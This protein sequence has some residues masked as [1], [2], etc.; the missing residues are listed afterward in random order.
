MART[1][2]E[3]VFRWVQPDEAGDRST[4]EVPTAPSAE[5]RR[6]ARILVASDLEGEAVTL[7]L[8]RDGPP[9]AVLDLSMQGLSFDAPK[10]LQLGE[11]VSAL[12]QLGAV[13]I[14]LTLQLVNRRD[15][16]SGFRV[17]DAP[18][19]WQ[20]ETGKLLDPIR[21]GSLLQEI[22]PS[23]VRQEPGE[24]H[25]RW[26]RSAPACDLYV[27][28]NGDG[29]LEQVQLFYAWRLVEW[30]RDLGLRTG[31]VEGPMRSVDLI[32][33]SRANLFELKSPPDPTILAIAHRLLRHA[34]VPDKVKAAFR[35]DR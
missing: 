34:R 23:A 27:W 21:V 7:R 22:D 28:T 18:P 19:S 26:Y 20:V 5:R 12:V 8:Q 33:F 4:P 24:H 13:Q 17:V 9:L 2:L 14:P 16:A 15:S 10:T 25:L 32:E 1:L 3:R 31:E 29:A 11:R 35:V 6:E 30:S